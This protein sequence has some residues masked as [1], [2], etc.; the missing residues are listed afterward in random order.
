M[1]RSLVCL[2]LCAGL[3]VVGARAQTPA[4]LKVASEGTSAATSL[5]VSLPAGTT[6]RFGATVNGVA[7]YCDAQ[8]FG[9]PNT[10]VVYYS[11]IPTCTV[12]GVQTLDPAPGVVKELDVLQ[13]LAPYTVTTSNPLTQPPI[14]ASL[15]IPGL[16]PATTLPTAPGMAFTLTVSA[17][18]PTQ[19]N[20][21]IT[22]GTTGSV[23]LLCLIGNI[24][25]AAAIAFSCVVTGP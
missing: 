3:F 9:L 8:T 14:T 16:L 6:W 11:A 15:T 23:P 13:G 21:S 24:D 18:T 4:W 7:E 22:N 10:F 17:L 25:P 19:F 20:L 1:K 12:L 5:T 2:A